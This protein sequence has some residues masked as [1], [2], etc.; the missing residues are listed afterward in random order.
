MKK[1]SKCLISLITLC[2]VFLPVTVMKSNAVYLVADPNSPE[3][4]ERRDSRYTEF[5]DDGYFGYSGLKYK[6]YH[7]TNS[8][9]C[10]YIYKETYYNYQ[11]TFDIAP[12]CDVNEVENIVLSY[13]SRYDVKVYDF[14]NAKKFVVTDKNF[15][16]DTMNNARSV[17][18]ELSEMYEIFSFRYRGDVLDVQELFFTPTI[19][20][21]IYDPETENRPD[22]LREYLAENNIDFTV[23]D[24][25]ADE[26]YSYCNQKICQ[27]I[28]NHDI[29]FEEHFAV[30]K[31]ITDDLGY[32][33]PIISP[34]EA[35]ISKMDQIDIG[36]A[37]NGDAN[38]DGKYTIADSTA[39][40][41]H[42]GNEDK[43]GLSLQGEFNADIYN[44]GDGVTPMDA[45][46]VQKAMASKG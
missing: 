6:V 39:I 14:S 37:V 10:S 23:I 43:Y 5:D 15:S 40:L 4:I 28:P 29:T 36:N 44:V 33:S 17:F 30:A 27:I 7:Y 20:S 16:S 32:H 25:V 2:S 46:E 41:Q 9:N 12:N 38:C 22:L 13:D 3:Y 19:T 26:R 45:L 8:N 35:V 24:D 21:Y 11:M 34:D 18:N 1:V 42:L 31:K